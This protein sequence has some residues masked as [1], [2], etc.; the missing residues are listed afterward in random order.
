MARL[1][2]EFKVARIA[3]FRVSLQSTG[4]LNPEYCVFPSFRGQGPPCQAFCGTGWPGLP[5]R[6]DETVLI[7]HIVQPGRTIPEFR[8]FSYYSGMTNRAAEITKQK[9]KPLLRGR[10]LGIYDNK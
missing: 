10:I 4:S 5:A 1:V 6:E 3:G 9:Q 8:P 7:G 2:A